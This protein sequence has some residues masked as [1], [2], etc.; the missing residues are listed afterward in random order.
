MRQLLLTDQCRLLYV[1]NK[2]MELKGVIK[3]SPNK[4][5]VIYA[6]SKLSYAQI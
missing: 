5:P 2:T 4:A 3:W 1:D 6:V